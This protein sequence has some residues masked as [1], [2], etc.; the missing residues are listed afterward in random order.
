MKVHRSSHSFPTL[1][2]FILILC[3]CAP[4]VLAANSGSVSGQ[5]TDAQD[6]SVPGAKG[7]ATATA[8]KNDWRYSPLGY[9]AGEGAGLDQR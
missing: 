9:R 7:K 6:G 2:A 4:T 1:L 3:F 5:L 8:V